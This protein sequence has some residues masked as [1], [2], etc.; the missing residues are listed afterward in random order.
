MKRLPVP[1]KK[2]RPSDPIMRAHSILQDVISLSNKPII[3]P[4]IKKPKKKP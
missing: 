2:S 1:T 4:P 3:A